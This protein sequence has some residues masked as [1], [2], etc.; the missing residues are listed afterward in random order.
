MKEKIFF[1]IPSIITHSLIHSSHTLTP[2]HSFSIFLSLHLALHHLHSP[3]CILFP[4]NLHYYLQSIIFHSTSKLL[5][6]PPL[7]VSCP[8]FPTPGI[9]PIHSH[10]P[11]LNDRSIFKYPRPTSNG[12]YKHTH[13]LLFLNLRQITDTSVVLLVINSNQHNQHEFA[14]RLPLSKQNCLV[15]LSPF[16]LVLSHPHLSLLSFSL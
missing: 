4:R 10:H 12:G 13:C 1:F 15:L 16:L 5:P 6:S 3:S 11:R 9:T 7:S 2:F 8:Q 14:L